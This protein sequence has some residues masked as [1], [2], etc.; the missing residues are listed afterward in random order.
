MSSSVL[1]GIIG[2]APP[3]GLNLVQEVGHKCQSQKLDT[4]VDKK[5]PNNIDLTSIF[6]KVIGDKLSDGSRRDLYIRCKMNLTVDPVQTQTPKFADL[7]I[8]T[9]GALDEGSVI[10]TPATRI[11]RSNDGTHWSAPNHIFDD[12]TAVGVI[13]TKSD[14]DYNYKMSFKFGNTI[15]NLSAKIFR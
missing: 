1:I 9:V 8:S 11:R 10:S 6:S 13:E 7:G 15:R 2:T 5:L 3:C 4:V 12:T 14:Y